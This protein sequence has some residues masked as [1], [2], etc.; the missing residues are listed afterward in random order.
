MVNLTTIVWTPQHKLKNGL[1]IVFNN[2]FVLLTLKEHLPEFRVYGKGAGVCN[3]KCQYQLT[4]TPMATKHTGNTI[5]QFFVSEITYFSN[6]K[7]KLSKT[8]ER[9]LNFSKK[10]KNQLAMPITIYM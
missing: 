10:K 1:P 7:I 3:R 8:T 4:I 9:R 2:V 5:S 6:S